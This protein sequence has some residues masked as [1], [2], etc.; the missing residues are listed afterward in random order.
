M[1]NY[2]LNGLGTAASDIEQPLHRFG[3]L[4]NRANRPCFTA[5]TLLKAIISALISYKHCF[6]TLLILKSS[7]VTH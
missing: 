5:I 2:D 1:E 3:Y 4:H 7:S 6:H